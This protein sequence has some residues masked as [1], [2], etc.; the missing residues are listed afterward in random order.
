MWRTLARFPN[1]RLGRLAELYKSRTEISHPISHNELLDLC[2]DY[3]LSKE[4]YF[5]DRHPHSFLSIINY[6]RTG[7]LHLIDNMCV[8]SY[9][10]DLIYWDINEFSFEL[11]CHN[12]YTDKKEQLEEELKRESELLKDDLED[13]YHQYNCCS[14]IR[15]KIWD[16]FEHPHT[17][18]AARVCL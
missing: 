18:K 12:K 10:D 2:D 4:E 16:L 11:C 15:R 9:D 3:N 13:D 5:F 6:Y 1:T 7:K 17:S 8:I 14:N